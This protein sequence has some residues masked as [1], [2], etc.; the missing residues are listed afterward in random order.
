MS[1]REAGLGAVRCCGVD[2]MYVDDSAAAAAVGG[3]VAY[4]RFLVCYPNFWSF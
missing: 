2:L 3:K 1:G 4:L